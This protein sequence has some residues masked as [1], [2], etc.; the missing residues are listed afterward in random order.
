M[1]ALQFC[2]LPGYNAILIRDTFTNLTKP[3][4]LIPLAH[5]WLSGT[6]ARWVGSGSR[7][8]VS[9]YHFP[10]GATLSFGYLDGP[11]DHFQYQSA[12]YQFVGIDEI[13]Q[14]RENQALY[15]FSRMRKAIRVAN[16]PLR[17]RA[18]S[19]PPAREQVKTGAWV[20]R[21][22]VDPKTREPG[23]V[24][25]PARL[26]DNPHLNIKEYKEKSLSKLDPITRRQLEEGDWEIQAK[27][28]MFQREWFPIVEAAPVNKIN[29][30][31]YWD[32]AATEEK[33]GQ[34][35]KSQAART[36][37]AKVGM[38]PDG[39]FFVKSMVKERVI[40]ISVIVI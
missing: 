10:S 17:F 33:E 1:A 12:A 34:P 38:T 28:R 3:E 37:G 16:I 21:R 4:G 5:E 31:R 22:Y 30:V 6:D 39:L 26:E 23:V 27:G 15:M 20:K 40:R 9:G 2:D 25:I 18:A 35:E 14:I 24:F 13:V 11:L 8:G 36:A 7:E 32:M 19:N 29:W